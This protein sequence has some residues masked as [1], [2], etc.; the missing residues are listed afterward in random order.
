MKMAILSS[1]WLKLAALVSLQ[2]GCKQI[3]LWP[4][5]S[6]TFW[7]QKYSKSHKYFKN[8]ETAHEK[9]QVLLSLRHA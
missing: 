1:P 2:F 7:Q 5:F 8:T 6:N 9:P 3:E 4:I